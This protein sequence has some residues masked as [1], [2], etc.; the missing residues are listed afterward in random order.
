MGRGGGEEGF[1]V[2]VLTSAD[3]W[4]VTSV[5]RVSPGVTVSPLASV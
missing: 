1:R 5:L 2:K 3:L 4:E